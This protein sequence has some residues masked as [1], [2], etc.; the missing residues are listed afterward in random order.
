M[1]ITPVGGPV[2]KWTN[3]P[4]TRENPVPSRRGRRPQRG[5]A[6]HSDA[7]DLFKSDFNRVIHSVNCGTRVVIRGKI[8]VM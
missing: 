3:P 2:V 4:V 7:C 1:W 6:L 8:P 5:T